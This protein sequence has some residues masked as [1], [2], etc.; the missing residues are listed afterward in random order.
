[1]PLIAGRMGGPVAG[2]QIV[3]GGLLIRDQLAG[4]EGAHVVC[5]GR[6]CG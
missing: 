1:M 5:R 6:W 4:I 2:N 3:P